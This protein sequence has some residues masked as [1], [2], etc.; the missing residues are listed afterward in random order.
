LAIGLA[1]LAMPSV[2][3]AGASGRWTPVGSGELRIS[4]QI[5]V[6]RTADGTLH[7]AW[8]RHGAGG[9]DALLQTPVSTA[10]VVGATV[11]IVTAWASVGDPA[12]IAQG[13]AL[14]VFFPA[15][16]TL[17]TGDPHDGLDMAGSADG[18]GSWS[19]APAAVY[20]RDFAGART[21]S[22][23][24]TG[25]G[26]VQSWYAASETVVHAGIDPAADA[27]RGYGAGT[28][29]SVASD[30]S[31]AVVVAWCTAVEGPNGVYVAAVDPAT[32]APAAPAARMPGRP[33]A[34]D[35]PR[36]PGAREPAAGPLLRV[37]VEAPL[38]RRRRRGARALMQR[39]RKAH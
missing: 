22:A 39:H 25:A 16:Q 28:N 21:P 11:P 8:E 24:A 32:G 30:P 23:T 38:R 10:G 2:A 15:T 18:G 4:E 19:L 1:L 12:L 36:R 17:T 20:G 9:Q 5:G 7:V 26:F 13:G 6:A 37:G 35:Q 27:Q 31:G 3:H 33:R 29:Q 34:A 14:T